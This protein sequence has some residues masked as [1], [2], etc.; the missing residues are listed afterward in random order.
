MEGF[1]IIFAGVPDP[2]DCNAGHALDEILFIALAAMLCGAQTC[3]DIADFGEAKETLLRR[4]LSLE[5]GI[6]SH[7]TFSRIFRMLDPEAFEACF[8]RFVAAFA[9]AL[10]QGAPRGV[11]AIDGKSLRGAYEKG[12]V[13]MPKMIVSAFAAETRMTLAQTLAP[14]GN[15]VAGALRVLELLSLK[16]CIVTA[17]ALHCH[18]QM[19]AAVCAAKADYVLAVKGNQS[20]LAR[21]VD[22]ILDASGPAPP[23]AETTDQ[24]HDRTEHRKAV[25]VATPDLAAKYDFPGLAAVGRIEASR[26]SNGV[27][28]QKMRRFLLSAHLTPAKLL[29]TVR[30][31]WSIENGA[32]WPLDVV[33]DEDLARNRKDNGPRNLA[34]LRRM[35]LNIL[36]AHPD[37]GSLAVKRKRAGWNDDFLISL[38]THMQ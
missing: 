1:R 24:A 38:W 9:V 7:D 18:K 23:F 15:E 29:S 36:R 27:T 35:T 8:Q 10:G 25:V 33:L 12:Q 31:H 22:V 5:H 16:G 32:H 37:K 13:H 6:P 30:E 34:V 28:K 2:R 26:T 19:A 3:V 21:D 20:A 4:F 17:D 11:V 14:D